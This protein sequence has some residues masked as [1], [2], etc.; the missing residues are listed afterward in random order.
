M[1]AS[2]FSSN[3]YNS[4]FRRYPLDCD[5]DGDF[6]LLAGVFYFIVNAKTIE[7]LGDRLETSPHRLEEKPVFCLEESADDVA[8][9]LHALH[10]GT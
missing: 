7:T 2:D 9:F 10:N 8:L 3:C 1:E 6:V 5:R 4:S